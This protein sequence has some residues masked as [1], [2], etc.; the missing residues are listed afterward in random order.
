MSQKIKSVDEF[1]A[2]IIR[3]FGIFKLSELKVFGKTDETVGE[4]RNSLRIFL[5]GISCMAIDAGYD[6]EFIKKGIDKVIVEVE[7]NLFSK[8]TKSHE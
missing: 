2:N 1:A 4:S 5:A 3:S 6:M 7:T 8:A